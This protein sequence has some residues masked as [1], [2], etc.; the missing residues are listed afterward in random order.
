MADRVHFLG[1]R[2]DVVN[3]CAQSDVFVMPSLREGLPVA[4]LE[5]MYC[6]LPLITSN[7]RGLVDI[8][9]N[10]VS[11]YLC[12][13]TDSTAFAKAI[14]TLYKNEELVVSMKQNNTETVKPYLLQNTAKEIMEI[15]DGF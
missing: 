14:I 15:F 6:G 5:A 2:T 10:G 12:S 4:S 9:Q 7:I 11:G 3:I 8:M 1:Y 13:P